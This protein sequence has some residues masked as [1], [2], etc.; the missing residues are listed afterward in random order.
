VLPP[1][2]PNPAPTSST[3]LVLTPIP[4]VAAG[5][6]D[7]NAIT[8]VR[9]FAS[10]AAGLFVTLMSGGSRLQ[11]AS[12]RT[13]VSST[14]ICVWA[15]KCAPR[16]RVRWESMNTTPTLADVNPVLIW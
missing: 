6:N 9:N 10:G 8:G 14:R 3:P 5:L 12:A 7:F 1:L 16:S 13:S 4:S 11:T 15:A 2:P